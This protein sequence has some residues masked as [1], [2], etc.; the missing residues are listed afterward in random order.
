MA[1]QTVQ[2]RYEGARQ[3]LLVFARDYAVM[4]H[5]DRLTAAL[6]AANLPSRE[7]QRLQNT[8]TLTWGGDH[9]T[10]GNGILRNYIDAAMLKESSLAQERSADAANSLS[11][12]NLILAAVGVILAAVQVWAALRAGH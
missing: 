7:L 5:L 1:K 9:R 3:A 4:N 10:V 12:V 8:L 11:I 6:D 2:Q